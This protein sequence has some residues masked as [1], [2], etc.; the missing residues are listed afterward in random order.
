MRLGELLIKA[1]AISEWQLAA[2]LDEQG[3]RG[4]LLGEILVRQQALPEDALVAALAR[5]LGILRVEP[6]LLEA[7]DPA[8]VKR[9][10][11]EIALRLRALPV[12]LQ[13]GG[14]VLGVA[15]AEPQN[16]ALLDELRKVTGCRLA[17][18]L[19][20]AVA[21]G[22]ALARAYGDAFLDDEEAEGLKMV[23]HQ[24]R[25]LVKSV[26]QLR[27][28]AG[29][30]LLVPLDE[31]G[32]GAALHRLE[33]SQRKEVAALRAMVELLIERGVFSRD[34]YLARLRR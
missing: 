10:S 3:S 19:A 22:Y 17:P 34:E 25:T 7:P 16:G 30:P 11:A 13:D 26:D 4:G 5:T 20:G 32:P 24:G 6:A 23:D 1:E 8:A 18:R 33:E 15:L 27:A 28:E 14:K 21:L 12:S 31:G 9:L 2:A 29:P